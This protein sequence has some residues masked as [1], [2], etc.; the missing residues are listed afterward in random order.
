MKKLLS[1]VLVVVLV[2]SIAGCGATGPA[3]N[4]SEPKT[5][6]SSS[7][8]ASDKS[9]KIYLIPQTMSNPFYVAMQDGAKEAV[10]EF[11]NKGVNIELVVQA[12]QEETDAEAQLQI[13]ENAIVAGADAILIVAIS[14]E[15]IIPGVVKANEAGIKVINVDCGINFDALKEKGG[16]IVTYIGSDNVEGGY[17]AGVAM[18]EYFKNET[19]KVEVGLIEGVPGHANAEARKSGFL[20]GI[21]EFSNI[22][23]VTSQTANFSID[24]AYPVM[25]N[26]IQANPNLKGV[27]ACS[28]QMALGAI[29]AIKDAGKTGEIAVFSFDATDVGL[30]A[31]KEGTMIGTVAQ[32]PAEMGQKGI[33]VAVEA[34]SD[35]AST[36]EEKIYTTV[37]VITEDLI[38]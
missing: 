11:K 9:Y 17:L 31:V 35:S 29:A 25:Q 12:P 1:L 15:G 16:E 21:K 18:G 2:F 24:Q 20:S 14:P 30:D 38:N 27:F 37:K 33:E 4:T 34:L 36:F 22:E 6:E 26:M 19:G 3:A 7:P 10:A 5:T 8:S 28:D 32:Y 23:C 13:M